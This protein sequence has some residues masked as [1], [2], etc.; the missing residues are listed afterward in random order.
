MYF[1][2]EKTNNEN[3]IPDPAYLIFFK[4]LPKTHFCE[5]FLKYFVYF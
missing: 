4:W 5:A 3:Q 2:K 1:Y